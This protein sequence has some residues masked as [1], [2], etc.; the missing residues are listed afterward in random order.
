MLSDRLTLAAYPR[1]PQAN[2]TK[3][4]CPS[5]TELAAFTKAVVRGDIVWH[6]GPFNL[7]SENVG[8]PHLFEDAT[9]IATD[10]DAHFGLKTPEFKTYNLRDVPGST[11]AVVPL[12]VNQGFK[13]ISVGQNPGTPS[14]FS[15]T[16][17]VVKWHDEA[18]GAELLFLN[19]N[20]SAS[21]RAI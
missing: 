17:R 19:H 14:V 18:S 9:K 10:L 6:H 3:L 21:P 1:R 11:R 12:L 2:G 20:V 8:D 5:K 7:E 16:S 4:R 15:E 13:A